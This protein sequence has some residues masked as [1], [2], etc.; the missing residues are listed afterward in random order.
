MLDHMNSPATPPPRPKAYSYLR[1]STPEQ[2]HGDSYRRQA[3]LAIDYAQRHGLDLDETLTFQDLGVSAYRGRN[4]ASGALRA[5]LNAAENGQVQRGSYLLVENLDRVSRDQIVSAQGLFMMIMDA[6]VTLVTLVDNRT[7][8]TASINA[9]PTELIISILSLM[10]AHEESATKSLRLSASW[11]AKRSRG[12]AE[13]L[14]ARCPAWLRLDPATRQFD[15]IPDRAAIV[16]RIFTEAQAGLGTAGIA[17]RLN[18][19]GVSVFGDGA[20]KGTMWHRTYIAKVLANPATAGTFTPH[21]IDYASGR[22]RR[23]PLDPIPD[24]FPAAVTLDAFQ[25]LQAMRLDTISPARGRHAS[26]TVTNV[27]GGLCHCGTCGSSMTL[28]IK[29]KVWRYLVCTRARGGGGCQYRSV[30]YLDV[31]TALLQNLSA[32]I[33]DCPSPDDHLG[34]QLDTIEAT[35]DRYRDEGRGL[36]DALAS[37]PHSTMIRDRLA[38]IESQIKGLEAE[39]RTTLDRRVA[40]IGPLVTARL[41][42]LDRLAKAEPLDRRALNAAFR[43]VLSAVTLDHGQGTMALKWKHGGETQLLYGWPEEAKGVHTVNTPAIDRPESLNRNA[44]P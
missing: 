42:E 29:S 11:S 30:R 14:T 18:E 24:Y 9:N 41:A 33:A 20:R 37:S 27:L 39:R 7:Y 38:T 5:F 44:T 2:A 12:A 21:R 19:Q 32:V 34:D 36:L 16:R 8:S 43:I 3:D 25:R 22:K 4:G 31:E 35:L 26:G 40:S 10:R 28:V 13:A 1:F 6:G 15:L 17:R 23:I